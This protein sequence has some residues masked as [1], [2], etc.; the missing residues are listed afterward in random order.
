M[1]WSGKDKPNKGGNALGPLHNP[2]PDA[3]GFFFG[4]VNRGL[5]LYPIVLV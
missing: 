1:K 4:F 5:T 3:A 2:L